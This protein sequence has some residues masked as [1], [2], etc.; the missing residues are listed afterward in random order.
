MVGAIA[1]DII[2]SAYE[3][4]PIKTTTFSLFSA[5]SCFTDDTVLTVATAEAFLDR[6]DYARTYRRLAR[7]Y[8]ASGF[9][10][11]FTRW[12]RAENAPPYNSWGNGSAMRVSP[13]GWAFTDE[14]RVL[15][16]AE[17]S[18]AVTHNHA[19]GIRGAQATALAILLARQGRGRKDIRI[20]LGERFGYDLNRSVPAIRPH[21]G[22]EIACQRSVPEAI[23][24]FLESSDFESAV[25][26]AVSLGGDSDT[27]ACIA[28]AIAEA[29]YGPLPPVIQTE[30]AKRI[31]APFRNVIARFTRRFMPHHWQPSLP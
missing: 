4:A 18:A 26:N 25:R 9:G 16:E 2:G 12:F 7:A 24:C 21:Y 29:Y 11:A 10:A 20:A 30:I 14:S 31:P 23:I 13:V 27:Q 28:G 1:G 8:P 19:E 22:F 6:A 3:A 5:R 17:K 15:R